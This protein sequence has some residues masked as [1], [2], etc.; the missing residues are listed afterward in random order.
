LYD[1]NPV[2]VGALFIASV[3]SILCYLGLFGDVAKALAGFISIATAMFLVP[4]IAYL[5]KGK[6]YLAR[7]E[8]SELRLVE[9]CSCVVCEHEYESADMADCPAYSRQ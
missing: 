2:G 5:T 7:Q 4:I 8:S 6:Y 1:I 9:T 3:L